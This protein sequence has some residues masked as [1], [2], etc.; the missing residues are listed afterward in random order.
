MTKK[1]H[2]NNLFS[3][4]AVLTGTS[5]VTY[6]WN[7]AQKKA[8]YSSPWTDTDHVKVVITQGRIASNLREYNKEIGENSG[9]L[10]K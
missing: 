9:K 4:Y 1:S 3:I 5:A 7:E 8:Y 2:T 10:S 6:I